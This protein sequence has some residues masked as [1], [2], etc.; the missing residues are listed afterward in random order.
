MKSTILAT[1]TTCMYCTTM[2]YVCFFQYY[3]VLPDH[4]L[5][6]N[7]V[8]TAPKC[9]RLR[10]NR[11]AGIENRLAWSQNLGLVPVHGI[12]G[13]VHIV[14]GDN[15]LHLLPQNVYH[16]MIYA[17]SLTMKR[18][19]HLIF[20]MSR[21][22]TSANLF[23]TTWIRILI[24]SIAFILSYCSWFRNNGAVIS[25][26]YPFAGGRCLWDRTGGEVPV[27]Y[28]L[29]IRVFCLVDLEATRERWDES[30]VSVP[31]LWIASVTLRVVQSGLCDG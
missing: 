1:H 18:D 31:G 24:M 12:R 10:W 7:E 20:S 27:L 23:W 13:L 11:T 9:V 29:S 16:R 17:Y 14:R 5:T 4:F 3:D 2:T 30:N 8:D 15:H 26:V 22:S 19:V 25:K 21:G 28:M 6:C